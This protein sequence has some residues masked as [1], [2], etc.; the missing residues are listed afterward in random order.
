[1]LLRLVIIIIII[2]SALGMAGISW[3]SAIELSADARRQPVQAVETFR[4]QTGSDEEILARLVSAQG[5][6]VAFGGKLA[7]TFEVVWLRLVIDNPHDQD[8][9]RILYLPNNFAAK[10]FD[11]YYSRDG[12][13]LEHSR[14]RHD[15]NEENEAIIGRSSHSGFS[16]PRDS[17]LV[18]YIKVHS[19]YEQMSQSFHIATR[20]H[21]MNWDILSIYIIGIFLG[22]LIVAVLA[23]V[24]QAAAYRDQTFLWYSAYCASLVLG[25][26][27]F[28]GIWVRLFSMWEM[29]KYLAYTGGMMSLVTGSLF[30]RPLLDT[31][32]LAPWMDKA[33][34][35]VTLI[36]VATFFLRIF[37]ETS[38]TGFV[39]Q[40]LN[41]ILFVALACA[42]GVNAMAHGK[43]LAWLYT[44]SFLFIAISVIYVRL[45][46]MNIAPIN[47]N[48]FYAPAAAH[49]MQIILISYVMFIRSRRAHI[50]VLKS[51]K[52]RSMNERLNLLLKIISHDIAS[53]L[54]AISLYCNMAVHKVKAELL[55]TKELDKAL[56]A[57]HVQTR[58]IRHAKEAVRQMQ[59]GQQ[60]QIQPVAVAQIIHEV[61]QI[62]Q[63]L[64][65]DRGIRLE[66]INELREDL[67]IHTDAT[68][69]VHNILGNILSNSIKFTPSQGLIQ[70]RVRCIKNRLIFDLVDN[71]PGMSKDKRLEI[72]TLNVGKSFNEQL[73]GAGSFGLSI[74][75]MCSEL[76]NGQLDIGPASVSETG[77]ELG[78]RITV[79]L[80]LHH[81]L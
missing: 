21:F 56:E 52:N 45:S 79:S 76:L 44:S 17:R 42:A 78:L 54:Q 68:I 37:P 70:I 64:C 65:Q 30:M 81:A 22:I 73:T 58:I 34:H 18:V 12:V 67:V 7:D 61:W 55:P 57:I 36:A 63:P 53:P 49:V 43:E 20:A 2:S 40:S 66:L 3:A 48:A 13:F 25:S 59:L 35:A 5:E 4:Q 27:S 24:M 51:Q 80:P 71:G 60:V 77:Q 26:L 74:L 8:L 11:F 62:F 39:L 10:N 15:Q 47:P 31:Q 9:S 69:L 75:Q 72:F 38:N 23:N 16:A 28:Y 41:S 29:Q 1:M 32:K 46:Q 50:E 19:G 14:Y 33:F 6:V